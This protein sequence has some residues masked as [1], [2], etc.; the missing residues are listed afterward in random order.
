MAQ[1][2][3][4]GKAPCLA[5]NTSFMTG[6]VK[7]ISEGTWGLI[8]GQLST[9]EKETFVL[10][11]CL[12]SSTVLGAAIGAQTEGSSWPLLA[13]WPLLPVALVQAVTIGL[14][15]HLDPEKPPS[16]KQQ[17]LAVSTPCTS[18]AS[19]RDPSP[20]GFALM[21]RQSKRPSR[22]AIVGAEA[23]STDVARTPSVVAWQADGPSSEERHAE[24]SHAARALSAAMD[25]VASVAAGDAVDELRVPPNGSDE[26]PPATAHSTKRPPKTPRTSQD[27]VPTLVPT[28][29]VA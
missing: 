10:L 22:D 28:M 15:R 1:N 5:A 16:A 24:A 6:T 12:W 9:K 18:A 27:T 8:R 25:T 2:V 3:V 14:L 23:S 26:D 13:S 17:K 11:L 29:S 21:R 7:R 20:A 4:S 19:S